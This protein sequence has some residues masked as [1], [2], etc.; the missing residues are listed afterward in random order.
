MIPR[1]PLASL[2]THEVTNMPPHLGD[3]DLWLSDAALQEGIVRDGASWAEST[4]AGFG[5]IAGAAETFERAD[6]ANR[7]P[8]ELK[9]FDRYG[10]RINQVTYHPAYH[11]LMTIAV[12]NE[13]ASFAWNHA[14]P[15]SQVGNAALTYMFSQAEGGVD[16][17]NG[18]DLFGDTHLALYPERRYRV[19]SKVAV[20]S[21]RRPAT[22]PRPKNQGPPWVCS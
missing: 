20:N 12:E 13:I 10:M 16:V 2:P 18:N 3:Q 22:Y 21:L 19:D 15:G 7:Y 11:E 4:L 17:P 6:L 14:Q 8:P 5:K 9:A 1:K